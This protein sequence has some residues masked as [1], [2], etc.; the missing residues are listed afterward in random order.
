M[1]NW[2]EIF[3]SV[4][5]LLYSLTMRLKMNKKKKMCQKNKMGKKQK[6]FIKMK[7]MNLKRK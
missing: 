1:C 2:E 7:K 5:I 6:K 4:T 3:L